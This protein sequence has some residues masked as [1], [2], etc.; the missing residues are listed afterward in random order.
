M[1][2]NISTNENHITLEPEKT[3]LT[4]RL[5]VS[6]QWKFNDWICYNEYA[7]NVI[8]FQC[9]ISKRKPKWLLKRISAYS[10]LCKT[11]HCYRIY[12]IDLASVDNA[13][14]SFL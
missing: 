9:L 1:F 3:G 8:V 2:R 11:P 6:E 5:K 13:I 12:E 7:Y 14:I 10:T 4:R